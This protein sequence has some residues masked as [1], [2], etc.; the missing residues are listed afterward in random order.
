MDVLVIDL[1]VEGHGD[2]FH[3]GNL[4]IQDPGW[5]GIREVV[6]IQLYPDSRTRLGLVVRPVA[7]LLDPESAPPPEPTAE[8]DDEE[9]F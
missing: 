1:G 4:V 7:M 6:D 8:H 9:Q 3:P 2:P 5:T